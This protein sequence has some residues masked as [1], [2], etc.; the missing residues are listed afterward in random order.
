MIRLFWGSGNKS[1]RG[2]QFGKIPLG[3]RGDGR[4]RF[5]GVSSVND[6]FRD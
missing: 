5:V 4:G 1:F 6:V 2:F 3:L